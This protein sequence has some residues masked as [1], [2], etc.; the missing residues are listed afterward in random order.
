MFLL[1]RKGQ[2][3]VA[4]LQIYVYSLAS[5]PMLWLC[6]STDCRYLQGY[7][8]VRHPHHFAIPKIWISDTRWYGTASDIYNAKHY[9]IVPR[10]SSVSPNWYFSW[11][12]LRI[13]S[14]KVIVVPFSTERIET[15]K[16]FKLFFP[17]GRNGNVNLYIINFWSSHDYPSKYCVSNASLKSVFTHSLSKPRLTSVT[18]TALRYRGY[19]ILDTALFIER[20]SSK[21]SSRPMLFTNSFVT[22]SFWTLYRLRIFIAC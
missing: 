18:L 22:C 1:C 11:I 5:L 21:S 2:L 13:R 3:P 16:V 14:R 19:A 17:L 8:W 20:I 7:F 4:N 6:I 10:S 9:D 12:P 15:G